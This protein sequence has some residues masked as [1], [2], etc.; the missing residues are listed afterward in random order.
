M[1][2]ITHRGYKINDM[3]LYINGYYGR[4]MCSAVHNERIFVYFSCK[5]DGKYNILYFFQKEM[6][7]HHLW[8][9]Y[10][11]SYID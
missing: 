7:D 9:I 8:R 11:L 10:D 1:M 4:M 2:N 6:A 3:L 5:I